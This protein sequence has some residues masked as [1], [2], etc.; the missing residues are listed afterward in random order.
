MC[1]RLLKIAIKLHFML[2]AELKRALSDHSRSLERRML[3]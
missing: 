1:R 3:R 2:I